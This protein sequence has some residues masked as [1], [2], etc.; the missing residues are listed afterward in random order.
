MNAGRSTETGPTRGPGGLPVA[1]LRRIA[2]SPPAP[3][4]GERCEMCGEPIPEE[5]QHVVDLESHAMMCTCRP[6]YLLFTDATAHLRYRSVPDRYLSFPISSWAPASGTSW[7][8][9]VGLAFFFHS[10][11]WT[12]PSPSIRVPA[13]ATESELP[14][15]AWGAVLA[16]NPALAVRRRRTRRRC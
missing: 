2:S 16:R 15:E 5:H 8:F 9:P 10:S 4:A 14:L 13:G 11:N 3:P 6:C 12:G 1:L 7:K